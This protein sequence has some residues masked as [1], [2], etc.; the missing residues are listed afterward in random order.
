MSG[1]RRDSNQE[2]KDTN[3][4][5]TY[6]KKL[7]VDQSEETKEKANQRPALSGNTLKEQ[8]LSA[9]HISQ[10]ISDSAKKETQA[11]MDQI[12][13]KTKEAGESQPTVGQR[14]SPK[15]TDKAVQ[16]E[17]TQIT[18]EPNNYT[19]SASANDE[20]SAQANAPVNSRLSRMAADRSEVA[21]RMNE[22]RKEDSIVRKIV[23]VIVVT[24]VLCMAISLFS[25][26]RYWQS[27][28]KPLDPDSK[29]I[30]QV[31][32]PIGSSTKE[33]GKILQ[34]DKVIK[35][36][37]VFTYYVKMNNLSNFQGGYY[38]MSANMTLD[39]VAHLLQ[40]GGTAEPEALADAKLAI[41]EG[42]SIDQ[43]GDLLAKHT[44]YSKEEFLTFMQD[45]TFFNKMV[46][47]YP[48]LLT[49]ASESQ[50]MRYS[51]EG[52]LFPATYNYYKKQSLADIVEPMIAKMDSVMAS[53][54]DKVAESGMT[55]H[56]VLTLAS[57]VEKEGV[58]ADDRRKIARVFLN[59]LQQDMPL[60][61]DISV[62]YALNEQKVHLSNEDTAV[63]SPYNLYLNKG[64][65]PGPFDSPSEESI[66]AVLY[67]ADTDDL[68]FLAD[69]EDHKIYFAKTYEEHLEQKQKYIEDKK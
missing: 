28:L 51:L 55:V 5:V 66:D 42:Q 60:Q 1:N 62:L 20:E 25:F 8:V 22:R 6:K 67:P 12:T 2:E 46:A 19:S 53:K 14:I 37:F 64:Y 38:Q 34:D 68:Y 40:E 33:I 15:A 30:V 23:T 13:K 17:P 43:I 59:R 48:K 9:I 26:Y 41:P 39:D 27:S 56:Q 32:V 45:Q 69:I 31:E 29:K 36:G 57:L 10:E 18:Q 49:S 16:A 21:G 24:L 3:E 65:G 52:Y 35:S 7:H 47:A 58:S 11:S 4:K 63:D 50:N 44:K 61:S 54:Y